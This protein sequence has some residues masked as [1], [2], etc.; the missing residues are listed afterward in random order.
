MPFV[1]RGGFRKTDA[2]G[3]PRIA[4]DD[5]SAV[6]KP[7]FRRAVRGGR[8]DELEILGREIGSGH[9]QPPA[10][11]FDFARPFDTGG[12]D[13]LGNVA[14]VGVVRFGLV[15]SQA[16]FHGLDVPKRPSGLDSGAQVKSAFLLFSNKHFGV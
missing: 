13:E 6:L 1:T 14:G 11:D 4:F 16:P 5:R 7:G 2:L 8:G 15:R 10:F 12:F 3:W 9:E